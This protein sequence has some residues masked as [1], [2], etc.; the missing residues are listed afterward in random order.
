MVGLPGRG[1]SFI[2]NHVRRYL[3]WKGVPCRVFNA[4]NYRRQLLGAL[5]TGGAEFYGD[6]PNTVALR[7][8]MAELA[9]ED[10]INFLKTTNG[11][12]C[13]VLDATNTTRDRRRK[14]LDFFQHRAPTARVLWI[15][16]I[17][18]DQTVIREN[19]LRA[20][21]GGEDFAG[22]TDPNRVLED[23]YSR[24][25][26]YEKRYQS[27]DAH[28]EPDLSFIRIINVKE[29]VELHNIEGVIAAR[30]VYFLL[31]LH[32]VAY[33]IYICRQG[34]TDGD[35]A[36][37]FGGDEGLT[38]CG[39]AFANALAGFAAERCLGTDTLTVL[40]AA[41]AATK[42]TVTPMINGKTAHPEVNV[43]FEAEPRALAEMNYGTFALGTR[44][45]CARD[46]PR[47]F[48]RLFG[49]PFVVN[50]DGIY[51][52][53]EGIARVTPPHKATAIVSEL[54][55]EVT[56]SADTHASTTASP[57][58]LIGIGLPKFG[59][60]AS[61]GGNASPREFRCLKYPAY[62]GGFPRGESTRVV[63]VR[64]EDVILRIRR[65]SGPV[66]VV[67]PD[68][69]A[70]VLLAHLCDIAP[71]QCT[72]VRIPLHCVIEIGPKGDVTV[73]NL[74][75]MTPGAPSAQLQ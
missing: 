17:C 29:T 40:Y 50:A 46:H 55:E 71:E 21:F 30:V 7:E 64:I 41:N 75:T 63:A 8:Q 52:P 11:V 54:P 35:V 13:A 34:E 38:S 57:S 37:V 6:D 18:T 53:R 14:L 56:Y 1:K 69:P 73:N 27:I 72:N 62:N 70:R 59:L 42:S 61:P 10:V 19:I 45:T 26:N 67:C 23:F 66:L 31:N 32:P 3:N 20:K 5:E 4:G 33:P 65:A 15:E 74:M 58:P 47:T 60:Q 68:T 22:V 51:P 25:A 16:S 39:K 2:G 43:L 49:K 48:Q 9:C 36:G 12:C 24:I 44:F 28:I